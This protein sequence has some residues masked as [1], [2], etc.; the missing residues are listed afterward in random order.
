MPDDKYHPTHGLPP[1]SR[2]TNVPPEWWS[3]LER[4]DL[5]EGGGEPG[6]R[7]P[8]FS[9]KRDH[10]VPRVPSPRPAFQWQRWVSTLAL[11]VIAALLLTA[12]LGGTAPE[13]I[14]PVLFLLGILTLVAVVVIQVS[15]STR[16]R[17]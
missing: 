6:A 5:P 10:E 7:H 16:H 2:P 4:R 1:E 8:R 13:G 12:G 15:G 14:A 11:I 17:P 9:R 3:Q